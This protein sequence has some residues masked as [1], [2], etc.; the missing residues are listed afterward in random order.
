VQV[1]EPRPPAGPDRPRGGAAGAAGAA[2][3]RPQCLACGFIQ[4]RNPIA[5]VAGILLGQGPEPHPSASWV[6]PREATHLLLVRRATTRAGRWCI[7]CGYLE[8]GEEIRRGVAREMREETGFTVEVGEVYAVHSNF[9]DPDDPTV[10]TWFLVR[11]VAGE[12]R[13]GDDVDRAG[14]FPLASPPEPLAFPTDRTVIAALLAARSA[15][16]ERT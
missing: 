7:P 11:A 12:L 9:H 14:F 16:G 4:Y 6:A 3:D 2:G 1:E 15:A 13:A 8:Y 10:G 5:A